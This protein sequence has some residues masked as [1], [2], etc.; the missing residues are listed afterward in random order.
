MFRNRPLLNQYRRKLPLRNRPHRKLDR[1]RLRSPQR[2]PVRLRPSH[3]LP[4]ARRLS[5]R[6]QWLKG[7]KNLRRQLRP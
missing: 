1:S 7:S 4:R 3:K 2:P 6:L 5:R